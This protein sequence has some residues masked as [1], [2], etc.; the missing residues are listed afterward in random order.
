MSESETTNTDQ[1][2]REL[3]R[4]CLHG[5][6]LRTIDALESALGRVAAA[7]RDF[8]QVHKNCMEARDKLAACQRRC[9][10]LERGAP[11]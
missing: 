9:A 5:P 3:S 10:E 1:D 6:D 7:E 4:A 8:I 11:Q 2:A